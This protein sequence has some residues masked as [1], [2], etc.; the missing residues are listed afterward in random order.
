MRIQIDFFGQ[1]TVVKNGTTRARTIFKPNFEHRDE[2]YCSDNYPPTE[3][4]S[5]L[6]LTSWLPKYNRRFCVSAFWPFGC[7]LIWLVSF[8]WTLA[9][10][11][12]DSNGAVTH[13]GSLLRIC[14]LVPGMPN[15][16]LNRRGMPYGTSCQMYLVVSHS[17]H[18]KNQ[19]LT[20][21][22]GP[23]TRS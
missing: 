21:N 16:N 11:L 9:V 7:V 8:L 2:P 15:R 10:C 1:K 4:L 13:P 17:L 22:L 12:V 3:Y 6:K 20:S 5:L 19:S 14:F 18:T 23:P